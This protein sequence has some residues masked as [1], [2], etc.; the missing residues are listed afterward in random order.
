MTNS[1]I[2]HT[3]KNDFVKRIFY[4]VNYQIYKNDLFNN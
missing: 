3:Q 1:D 4:K 2:C